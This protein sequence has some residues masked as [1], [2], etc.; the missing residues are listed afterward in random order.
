MTDRDRAIL[1]V[2]KSNTYAAA[3]NT[4]AELACLR[5][6]KELRGAS[7]V[8]SAFGAYV[9]AAISV[10]TP[11]LLSE[12]RDFAGTSDFSPI[13]VVGL[14]RSGTTLTERILSSHSRVGGAGELQLISNFL[15]G[16]LA[17]R[18]LSE[19]STQMHVLGGVNV[20]ERVREIVE[21]MRFLRPDKE[22]IVDKMP[23]NFLR[24]GLIAALF[25]K[26]SI[27][28]CFRHPADNFLSGFKANLLDSHSYFHR[29]EWFIPYHAHYVR[30]MDHWQKVIPGRIF[31]SEYERLVTEPE[32][33]IRAMLAFCGLEW[34]ENCLYPEREGSRIATASLLQARNPINPKSVGGWKK[35]ASFLQ[36]IADQSSVASFK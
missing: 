3:K 19:F 1:Y 12:I 36:P 28:H 13:H 18:P 2:A 9:D 22:R 35:F 11:A 15:N 17:G 7:D 5:K 16:I 20:R 23:H 10:F 8:S 4:E 14:P 27:V 6:S 26:G 21:T 33:S 32:R 34:E 30:L 24:C 29:P 31:A 25:P